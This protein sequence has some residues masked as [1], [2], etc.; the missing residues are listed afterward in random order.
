MVDEAGL[1]HSNPAS[2]TSS[3]RQ[4]GHQGHGEEHFA[5]AEVMR[6]HEGIDTKARLVRRP[7]TPAAFRLDSAGICNDKPARTRAG[8][9]ARRSGIL[10]TAV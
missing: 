4:M 5:F 2:A 10:K 7:P 1:L 9:P 6:G 3:P 8:K